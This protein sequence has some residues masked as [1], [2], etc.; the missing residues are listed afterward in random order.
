MIK[1]KLPKCKNCSTAKNVVRYGHAGNG[2]Q[3]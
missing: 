2:T 1:E 3:R